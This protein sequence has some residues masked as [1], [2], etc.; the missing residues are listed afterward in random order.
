MLVSAAAAE[1]RRF[2]SALV[3][4]A[5]KRLAGGTLTLL[6]ALAGSPASGEV[7]AATRGRAPPRSLEQYKHLSADLKAKMAKALAAKAAAEQAAEPMVGAPLHTCM[8]LPTCAA[9]LRH[10]HNCNCPHP[11]R[12]SLSPC[13]EARATQTERCTVQQVGGVQGQWRTWRRRRWRRSCP[14]ATASLSSG[15]P[16]TAAA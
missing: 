5:A 1:R 16:T 10:R 15:A 13:T 4:R 8:L 9:L 11:S 7:T 3:Q 6:L 2:L 14:S 12:G